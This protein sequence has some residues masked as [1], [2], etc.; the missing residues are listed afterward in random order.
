MDNSFRAS[1]FH[2]VLITSASEFCILVVSPLD[3]E[4]LH[5]ISAMAITSGDVLLTYEG[6]YIR[7]PVESGNMAF[8]EYTIG[9]VDNMLNAAV[10]CLRNGRPFR[11]QPTL[12][13]SVSFNMKIQ[14]NCT[15]ANKQKVY[16]ATK[17]II[18]SQPWR[19][20]TQYYW[21]WY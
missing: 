11:V 15:L 3:T 7:I 21:H 8:L 6:Q 19:E 9:Y 17:Y 13:N 1:F 16:R 18:L 5:F 14:V 4:S 20:E 2:C 12:T 10:K